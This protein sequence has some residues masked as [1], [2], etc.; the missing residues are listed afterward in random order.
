MVVV[1][2]DDGEEGNG[3]DVDEEQDDAEEDVEA[4]RFGGK[5]VNKTYPIQQDTRPVTAICVFVWGPH[6]LMWAGW[7][8]G[9]F[10][11]ALCSP[12]LDRER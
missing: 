6:T 10:I 7:V 12:S 2:G 3:D 4:V 8:G 9:I 1:A 11:P 5:R